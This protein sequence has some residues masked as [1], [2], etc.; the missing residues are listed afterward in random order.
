MWTT[1]K[2]EKMENCISLS[3]K[4]SNHYSAMWIFCYFPTGHIQSY[5]FLKICTTKYQGNICMNFL[6]HFMIPF[7]YHFQLFEKPGALHLGCTRYFRL[8]KSF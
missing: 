4:K 1:Q 7:K 8:V 2:R 3:S 5:F 6:F